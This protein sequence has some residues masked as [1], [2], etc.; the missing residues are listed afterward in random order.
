MAH[1]RSGFAKTIDHKQ[2]D[3]SLHGQIVGLDIAEGVVG[4]GDIG[5]AVGQASTSLRWRGQVIMQLDTAGVD[6]RVL[7]ACGI[8]IVGAD[9]FTAGAASVPSP[10]QQ[11]SDDWIWYGWLSATSGAEAAVFTD[12]LVDRLEIDSKAMRKVRIGETFAF[13]AEVA[14][15]ADMGG[16]VD[17]MY[18]ARELVGT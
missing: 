5:S 7:V 13:V 6:E 1:R 10:I 4:L 3:S 12:G 17:I 11:A 18:G 15:T 14:D 8:I 2:W 9:A 16:T